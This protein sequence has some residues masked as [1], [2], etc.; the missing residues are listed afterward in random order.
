MNNTV[1]IKSLVP[2]V[3]LIL[4]FLSAL[5]LSTFG[6]SVVLADSYTSTTSSDR[7]F[8]TNPTLAI[9]P[10]NTAY[11][12]FGI[13]RTL[14][15]GTTS[16]DIARAT[17]KFYVNKVITPGRLDVYPITVDWDE[18]T[19]SAKNAPTVGRHAF[20]TPLVGKNTQ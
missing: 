6:Q 5:A 13:L 2:R 16:A 14:P 20:T 9:S 4:I 8:G 18:K 10:T 1:V 15:V 7:N 11:V 19:I 3:F 12:K 17:V